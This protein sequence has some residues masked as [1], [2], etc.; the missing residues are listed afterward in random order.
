[1]RDLPGAK[2]L[3]TGSSA[4]DYDT[5]ELS[6]SHIRTSELMALPL[7]I[8]LLI[9]VFGTL[10]AAVLPVL[11]AC[12]AIGLSLGCLSIIASHVSIS[13]VAQSM[14]S[15]LGLALGTDY[16]LLLV[17]SFREQLVLTGDARTAAEQSLKEAGTTIFLSG[18][19]IVIGL[20][21]LIII[22]ANELRSVTILEPR[23]IQQGV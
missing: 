3:I 17:T 13:V 15:L 18:S 8:F 4:I 20:S 11:L 19:T 10:T 6:N 2:I 7:I 5:I 9:W 14:T 12:L 21:A 23:A 1:M 22:P 16:A